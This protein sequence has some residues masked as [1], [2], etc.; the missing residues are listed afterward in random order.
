MTEKERMLSGKLY[1]AFGEELRGDFKKAKRLTA[2]YNVTTEDE[3][4]K[5]IKSLK[6]FWEEQ[7][8]IS[9]LNLRFSAITAVIFMLARTFTATISASCWMCARLQ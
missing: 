1:R 9:T 3:K 7:E 6:S 5:E 2:E 8:R 4:E